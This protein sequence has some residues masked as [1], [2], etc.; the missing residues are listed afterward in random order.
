MAKLKF[1]GFGGENLEVRVVAGGHHD[2]LEVYHNGK[3]LWRAHLWMD[4]IS[5]WDGEFYRPGQTSDKATDNVC[6]R[7]GGKVK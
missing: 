2:H 3:R 4:G 1:K 7:L 5:L 6:L